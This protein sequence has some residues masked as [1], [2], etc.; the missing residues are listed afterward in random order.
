MSMAVISPTLG[1]GVSLHMCFL[2]AYKQASEIAM[3][4]VNMVEM[5]AVVTHGTATTGSF[6][7]CDVLPLTG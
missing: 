2:P 1:T 3:P 6:Y 5:R 7:S 4:P